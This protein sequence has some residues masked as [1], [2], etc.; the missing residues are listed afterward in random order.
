MKTNFNHFVENKNFKIINTIPRSKKIVSKK[1]EKVKD[2][3]SFLW[4]TYLPSNNIKKK[5]T[6]WFA[7][8]FNSKISI[9]Q[10]TMNKKILDAGCGAGLSAIYFFNKNLNNSD[11]IGLD[12]SRAVEQAKANFKKLNINGNF[13]QSSIEHIPK[14]LKFDTIYSTGV[15]HH[16]DSTFKSMKKLSKHLETNG[17]FLGYVYKKKAPLRE[18]TDDYIREKVK[19]LNDRDYVEVLKPLTKLGIELGKIQKKIDIKEPIQILGIPKGKITIQR[20]VY[21]YFFKCYFDKN[22]TFK[23]MHQVNLDWYRPELCHRH[24]KEEV[25]SYIKKCNLKKILLKDVESGFSF[26]AKKE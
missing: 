8:L 11:Y 1:Q 24:T 2:T 21:Y 26:I 14:N 12:I 9:N 16:T 13:V 22:L 19:L 17:Y 6:K 3:Y 10:L 5:L 7:E 25:L 20:L 18:F 23:D 15:L 4:K